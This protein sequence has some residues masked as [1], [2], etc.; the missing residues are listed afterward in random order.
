MKET[1]ETEERLTLTPSF[2]ELD[3]RLQQDQEQAGERSEAAS[4]GRRW[5]RLPIL[6]VF[7]PLRVRCRRT[8]QAPR[9]EDTSRVLLTGRVRLGPLRLG[10]DGIPPGCAAGAK[11]FENGFRRRWM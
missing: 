9:Y 2:L 3:S 4:K 8:D 7:V 5:R 10:M 6:P 1:D 11:H